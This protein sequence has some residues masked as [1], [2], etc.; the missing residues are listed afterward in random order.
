VER[1]PLQP[2]SHTILKWCAVG[3]SPMFLLLMQAVLHSNCTPA[4]SQPGANS[5]SSC[6]NS[7]RTGSTK[8]AYVGAAS[9]VDKREGHHSSGLQTLPTHHPR[10]HATRRPGSSAWGGCLGAW[11]GCLQQLPEQ[12]AGQCLPL[13]CA[14]SGPVLAIVQSAA[15][16]KYGTGCEPAT[17][18]HEAA[19]ACTAACPLVRLWHDPSLR[20]LLAA[21][22]WSARELAGW[23]LYHQRSIQQ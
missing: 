15:G 16:Q 7:G 17:K 5:A 20:Q 6:A 13:W 14:A 4:L 23:L 11:G 22:C 19:T 10:L 1:S 3:F 18:Q 9:F 8:Q 12:S 2:P 21:H